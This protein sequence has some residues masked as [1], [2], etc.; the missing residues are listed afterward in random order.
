MSFRRIRP[1]TK[2]H[3]DSGSLFQCRRIVILSD[4]REFF[5]GVGG[6]YIPDTDISPI[7]NHEFFGNYIMAN[8]KTWPFLEVEQRRYRFR[9]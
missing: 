1:T 2:S 9:F 6:P 8:G 3:R 7:W 4:T 5:D